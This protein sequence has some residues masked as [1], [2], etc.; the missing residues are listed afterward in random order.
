MA[1]NQKFDNTAVFK[2]C[3]FV[4]FYTILRFSATNCRGISRPISK[5]FSITANS[6]APFS[7]RKIGA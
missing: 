7:D 1:A 2:D 3:S 6:Q 5:V 4:N